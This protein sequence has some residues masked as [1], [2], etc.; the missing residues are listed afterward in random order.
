[1]SQLQQFVIRFFNTLGAA[2]EEVDYALIEVLIDDEYKNIFGKVEMKLCFDYEVYLENPDSELVIFGSFILDKIIDLSFK[3]SNSCIRYAVGDN[4]NIAEPEKKIKKFLNLDRT[5]I[6]II[7]ESKIRSYFVKYSFKVK[8][9]SDN[10]IE[11]FEEVSIDMNSL[12]ISH[13]FCNNL[14]NIFY[15]TNPQYDYPINCNIDFLEGLKRAVEEIGSIEKSKKERL[16]SKLIID[17]EL[18]RINFYYDSLKLEC[19]KRMKRKNLSEEKVNDYKHKI[20]IYNIEKQRQINEIIEKYRIKSEIL[21]EN[22]VVYELPMVR[23]K[24]RIKSRNTLVEEGTC[25]YNTIFKEFGPVKNF[26]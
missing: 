3:F 23:F 2:I 8:Y 14:N 13:E 7:E 20:D 18:E 24:Y 5:N 1:M 17:K 11:E 22:A 19:E 16:S 9:I 6:E 21:F 12:S 26:V 10:T 15:E 25:I 4:L